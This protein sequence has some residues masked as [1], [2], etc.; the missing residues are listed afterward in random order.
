MRKTYRFKLESAAHFKA[1]LFQWSR[2]FDQV[3]CL[4]SNAH[5]AT[6][7][8]FDCAFAL[9]SLA[10]L[11]V[12]SGSAFK[13]LRNFRKVHPDWMFGYLGYDLKNELEALNSDNT[14]VL[15]FA[16]MHFV[17]P[18]R[19]IILKGEICSFS[20][21]ENLVDSIVTDLK[22]IRATPVEQGSEEAVDSKPIRVRLRTTKDTYFER[23]ENIQYHL[24]RGDIYET[25]FCQEF[26]ADEAEIDPWGIYNHLNAIAEAPFSTFVRFG[27]HYILSSS[28]ERYLQRRGNRVISQPIKGTAKRGATPEEDH[29]LK[30]ALQQNPKERSENIMITD[31][32]RNDLSQLAVP[33]TVAV[34]ALCELHSFKQVHQLISTVA[35]E[36]PENTDSVALIE[37]TFPMGSMT[38]APKVAAM[39]IAE[40]QEDFKRGVYSG[41]IGYFDPK[42]DFD[43]NVVIRSI[44]YN[45]QKGYLSFPVG[46]A[47]T[48][49]ANAKDEY[50][51]CLLKAKAMRQVLENNS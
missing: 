6:D 12:Q 4:D 25:N 42:G 5:A 22:A 40:A 19:L 36:V 3:V 16:D 7:S 20:Y 47:I 29:R 32:V 2:Q 14:D 11:E 38:G 37:A 46:G 28:P 43:F 34:E 21:P 17:V 26:Y 48:A 1:Q 27:E 49:A 9:G 23:F 31:L 30:T 44:L 10:Q 35:A 8:A 39:Q 45:A 51:E 50:E 18:E 33:G 41:A 24:H 15:G 13:A